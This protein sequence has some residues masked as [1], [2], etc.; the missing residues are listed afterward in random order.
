MKKFIP[1]FLLLIIVPVVFHAALESALD[2]TLIKLL[3]QNFESSILKDAVMLI[4]AALVIYYYVVKSAKVRSTFYRILICWL[5]LAIYMTYRFV[6]IHWLFFSLYYLPVIKY[7]DIAILTGLMETILWLRTGTKLLPL[8][9]DGES[10]FFGSRPIHGALEDKLGYVSYAEEIAARLNSSHF[11]DAFAIGINGKWGSGKSS[12]MNLVKEKL[13]QKDRIFVDFKPWN[14]HEPQAIIKDFFQTVQAAIAPYY[15]TLAKEI[16]DYGKK[17]MELH[18]HAIPQNLLAGLNILTNHSESLSAQ[19]EEINE[20]LK[21]TGLQLIIFIDDLDRLD[22]GEIQEVIRI[23][24]NTANFYNTIYLVAYDREYLL[25]AIKEQNSYQYQHFLEKIFQLEVNLPGFNAAVI[26]TYLED[27]LISVFGA[28][29][30]AECRGAIADL[31]GY[32]VSILTDWLFS[33]RDIHHV[34]NSMIVNAVQIREEILFSDMLKLELL[35][36]RFPKIYTDL[37]YRRER[38]LDA[39]KEKFNLRDPMYSLRTGLIGERIVDKD[40]MD[41]DGA[42]QLTND[43][44]HQIITLLQMLFKQTYSNQNQEYLAVKYPLNFSKYFF[45]SLKKNQLSNKEF[46]DA[47]QGDVQFF[48]DKI[49]EW[50]AADHAIQLNRLFERLEEPH[51]P[52]LFENMILGIIHMS[53]TQLNVSPYSPFRFMTF[54]LD[55]MADKLH[56]Y[57]FRISHRIYKDQDGKE[58]KFKNF[59]RSIFETAQHPYQYEAAL[60]NRFKRGHFLEKPPLTRQEIQTYLLRYFEDYLS[61]S[62]SFSFDDWHFFN[63]FKNGTTLEYEGELALL[64]GWDPSA[65]KL[66]KVHIAKFLDKFLL[67][68]ISRDVHDTQKCKIAD[69]PLQIFLTWAEF[70]NFLNQHGGHS[71]Y[72][73]EFSLFMK[74]SHAAGNNY[75]EYDFKVIPQRNDNQ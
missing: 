11:D 29:H 66:F 51:S 62:E 42:Y 41:P 14:A 59:V 38:W 5:M 52:H 49:D 50:L 48:Y 68:M 35:R 9:A 70:E 33:I 34:L 28:D 31:Y 44:A 69:Y 65:L 36:Y 40:L 54:N 73:S 10:A 22:K 57:N 8:R 26:K 23:I 21:R 15:A 19:Y 67:L 74:A 58:A 7:T 75:I 53:N 55:N 46:H 64:E 13:D 71:T 72:L 3:Y 45:Y 12:F 63:Y 32:K 39:D 56:D 16:R 47:W 37:F 60:L 24:R 27:G 43:D 30:A 1:V 18:D 61:K 20:N 6:Y 25:T 4:A 17:L 2:H